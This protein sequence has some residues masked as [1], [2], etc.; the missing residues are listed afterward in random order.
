MPRGFINALD[1]AFGDGSND[2]ANAFNQAAAAAQSEGKWLW[3]PRTANSYDVGSQVTIP[4]GVGVKCYG[5]LRAASGIAKT[6]PAVVI[7]ATGVANPFMEI[8]IRLDNAS[9][10]S[11]V[12]WSNT[13]YVG[14]RLY[15]PQNCQISIFASRG[16]AVGVEIIGDGGGGAFNNDL[17]MFDLADC[18][19]ALQL[20]A[21]SGSA[22]KQNRL[23]KGR[24]VVSSGASTAGAEL[25][26][27]LAR[28]ISSDASAA[29][30]VRGN[31][32]WAPGPCVCPR[33]STASS[34]KLFHLHTQGPRNRIQ[35]CQN[36]LAMDVGN[37]DAHLVVDGAQAEHNFLHLGD[38]EGSPAKTIAKINGAPNNVN[39]VWSQVDEIAN[40]G[41]PF[42][43]KSWTGT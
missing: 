11:S 26:R 42:H 1:W 31:V 9:L 33:G 21:R 15:N 18:R 2:D 22:V 24:W 27:G 23:W 40:A 19:Y 13:G 4:A 30:D 25:E 12:D 28:F 6:A 5:K 43:D 20:D 39:G 14:V 7:G 16:F 32:W 29:A 17:W 36:G 34:R 35:N 41:L 3:I 37:G 10:G 8:E 38:W